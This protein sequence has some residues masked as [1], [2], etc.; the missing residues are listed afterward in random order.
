ME[1]WNIKAGRLTRIETPC[2]HWES[3]GFPLTLQPVAAPEI[4]V[5]EV[6]FIIATA[7]EA[8][9]ILVRRG[10]HPPERSAE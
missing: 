4:I 9:E 8:G 1:L 5:I 3:R 2:I 10:G 6:K 7:L